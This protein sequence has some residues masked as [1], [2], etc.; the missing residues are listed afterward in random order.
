MRFG[1]KNPAVLFAAVFTL[2]LMS[3][4]GGGDGGTS[5]VAPSVTTDGASS[6]AVSVAVLNG[7][8]NPNGAE[9]KAW[10][11]WST[12]STLPSP[13]VTAKKSVGTGTTLQSVSESIISLTQ[14]TNYYYRVVAQNAGGITQ[15]NIVNRTTAQCSE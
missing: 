15:R 5:T 8:V 10:F 2:F 11:E 4:C 13:T 14:G 7:S 3:G 1:L 12:D 6:I 9:T